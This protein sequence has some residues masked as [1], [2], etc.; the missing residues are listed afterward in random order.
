MSGRF[1]TTKLALGVLHFYRRFISPHKGFACA[2]RVAF[3]G[4]SCS[5]FA[6]VLITQ[7]GLGSSARPI[8]QRLHE[9][10]KAYD[11][12]LAERPKEDKDKNDSKACGDKAL[13]GVV[14]QVTGCWAGSC[15]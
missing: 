8:W 4:P 15:F 9:C 6:L 5:D 11:L 13:R 3:G 14:E 12:L 1:G 10:R 7:N 2:H